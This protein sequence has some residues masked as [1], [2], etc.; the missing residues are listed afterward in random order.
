MQ[1][2]TELWKYAR[3][4][5]QFDENN[6]FKK[7]FLSVRIIFNMWKMKNMFSEKSDELFVSYNVKYLNGYRKHFHVHIAVMDY[8]Q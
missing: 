6:G 2:F 1:V 8:V 7:L 4:S 3:K 5:H